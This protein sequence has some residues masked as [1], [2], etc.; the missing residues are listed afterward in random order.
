MENNLCKYATAIYQNAMVGVQSIRDIEDKTE[1]QKLKKELTD[2]CEEFN[3][4]AKSVQKFANKN[5]FSLE[6][7][8]F[9]EK[10]RLWLSVNMGTMFDKSSRHI[11]E[12]MLIGSVMGLL[13]CYK[14]KYDHKDVSLEL[15]NI[16]ADLE[17]TLENN[18]NNLKQFLK[19]LD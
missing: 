7:N 16:I 10:S 18:F 12:L 11:A 2:E 6:E 4:I 8:N 9:F 17:K 5:G 1:D 13:T 3:K 15:D 19:E 14:D